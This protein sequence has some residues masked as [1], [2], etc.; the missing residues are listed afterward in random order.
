MKVI[1]LIEKQLP[2]ELY[3]AE[4][5]VMSDKLNNRRYVSFTENEKRL[6]SVFILLY[7]LAITIV[8]A[9]ALWRRVVVA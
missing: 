7:G 8:F 1:N 2:L 5:D 6:P 9:I 3:R 4:W